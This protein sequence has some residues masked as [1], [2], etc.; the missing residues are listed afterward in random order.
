MPSCLSTA[1][2]QPQHSCQGLLPD[3]QEC[4]HE[5]QHHDIKAMSEHCWLPCCQCAEYPTLNQ[6]QHSQHHRGGKASLVIRGQA[7]DKHS[8]HTHDQHTQQQAEASA[9]GV[10]QVTKQD[11]PR[12]PR[13]EAHCMWHKK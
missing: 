2:T 9:L 6:P 13:Q 3:A 1:S 11:G 12:R 8:G 5:A 7:A 10:T 4:T